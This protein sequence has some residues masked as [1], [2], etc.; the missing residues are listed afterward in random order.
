MDDL[1]RRDELILLILSSPSSSIL[2]QIYD[3]SD[4]DQVYSHLFERLTIDPTLEPKY[5]IRRGFLIIS[6]TGLLFPTTHQ[7]NVDCL[8]K[9]TTFHWKDAQAT[10][11]L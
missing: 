3:A 1:L 8:M 6:M 2:Q 11:V 4:H 10:K 9:L 7:S 5:A